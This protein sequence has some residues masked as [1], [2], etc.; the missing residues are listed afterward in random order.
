MDSQLAQRQDNTGEAH[1][2]FNQILLQ[3]AEGYV[4]R[5]V[6]KVEQDFIHEL[7]HFILYFGECE[8]TKDLF[9][10]ERV[11][12]RIALLLH[13][14]LTTMEYEERQERAR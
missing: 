10:N 6:T 1:Y 7:V 11:V 8:A 4:G 5:P 14:A 9:K 13:Q 3:G 12:D 2:R